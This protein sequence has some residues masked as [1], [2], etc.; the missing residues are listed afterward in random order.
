MRLNEIILHLNQAFSRFSRKPLMLT[1]DGKSY[2]FERP[3]DFAFATRARAT[4]S[5]PRIQA[6]FHFDQQQLDHELDALSNL[7]DAL[8]ETLADA[9]ANQSSL[10]V[11]LSHIGTMVITKD[12]GWREIFDQ[13]LLATP[14][15]ERYL[16]QALDD[17]F[18]YIRQRRE[19]VGSISLLRSQP[20]PGNT[21]RADELSRVKPSEIAT[22][23]F[24][25]EDL[26]A[27]AAQEILERLPQGRAVQLK[28]S[29]GREVTLK[30]A[31]HRFSL[32][33]DRQWRL[34]S[35]H[36]Q[37]HTLNAGPNSV[38]R[39]KKNHISIDSSLK[40]ISRRHLIAEPVG[41]DVIQLTDTSSCGTWIAREALDKAS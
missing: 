7:E 35:K 22:A 14:S 5:T 36:G 30:L 34:V 11:A 39:S 31:R 27:V 38:G 18:D 9:R 13:L 2:C 26:P 17:Y 28:L 3:T 16:R 32:A 8:S 40:N 10:G 19:L 37:I 25:A 23:T 12:N 4:N 6:L 21:T 24:N 1:L 20:Q 29:R 33:H 41:E 15:D